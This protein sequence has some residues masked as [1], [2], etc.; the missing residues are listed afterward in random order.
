M[1]NNIPLKSL[2][3]QLARVEV[4]FDKKK[5]FYFL[6]FTYSEVCQYWLMTIMDTFQNIIISNIPLVTGG[7]ILSSGNILKQFA[8]K[9]I[10][11]IMVLKSS[12]VNNDYPNEKQLGAEFKLIWGDTEYRYY[13]EGEVE[14]GGFN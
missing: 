11:S 14:S 5:H 1:V 8:Y 13:S 10:G 3:N 2:P 9:M 6:K 7:S 12:N 4:T